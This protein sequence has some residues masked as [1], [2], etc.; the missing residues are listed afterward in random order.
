MP[1]LSGQRFLVGGPLLTGL[2]WCH[3]LSIF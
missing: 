1:S 2:L 3:I